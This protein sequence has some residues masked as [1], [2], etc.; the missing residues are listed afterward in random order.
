MSV[1]GEVDDGQTPVA[2]TQYAITIT[3]TMVGAT[4]A[5]SFI[6]SLDSRQIGWST[7]ESQFTA[8]SAHL[9]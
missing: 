9:N 2:K 3:P 1:F 4:L 8:K 5:Q 6:H 7:I